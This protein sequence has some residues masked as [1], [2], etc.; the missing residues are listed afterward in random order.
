MNEAGAGSGRVLVVVTHCA[1]VRMI[2]RAGV[3]GAEGDAGAPAQAQHGEGEGLQ[4]RQTHLAASRRGEP[5]S[6][7]RTVCVPAST[8][9]NRMDSQILTAFTLTY[10]PLKE[11]YFCAFFSASS[12]FLMYLAVSFLKSFKQDLQQSLIS[13]PS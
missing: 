4:L 8:T 13:R 1:S 3:R 6:T 7:V 9:L 10:L 2:V 11:S 12:I 5:G